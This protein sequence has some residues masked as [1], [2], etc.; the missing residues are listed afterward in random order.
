[1]DK[2]IE[3]KLLTSEHGQGDG[4]GAGGRET[5]G[6]GGGEGLWHFPVRET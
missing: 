5:G 3:V 6:G 4:S 2:T 1:M